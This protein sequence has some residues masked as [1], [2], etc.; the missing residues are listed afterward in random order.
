MLGYENQ[1]LA[2]RILRVADKLVVISRHVK[3]D[4]SS[5]PSL[6][7]D[8]PSVPLEFPY[9]FFAGENQEISLEA[10]TADLTP[11]STPEEDV[12]HD[13]LEELP[14]RRIKVIGPRHPMLITSNISTDNILPFSQRTRCLE[15]TMNRFGGKTQTSGKPQ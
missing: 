2:Y 14:V 10:D 5:L 6:A 15:T 11:N 8:T 7:V 1:A 3:F 4:E 9:V 13:A 12:F